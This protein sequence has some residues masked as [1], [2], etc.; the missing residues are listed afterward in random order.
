MKPMKKK[1]LIASEIFFEKESLFEFLL[2]NSLENS[3]K[4][5]NEQI[6]TS[7]F[8]K[9]DFELKH[10]VKWINSQNHF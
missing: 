8:L 3:W 2:P 1:L 10:D 9:K 7:Q 6:K 5:Q 4:S